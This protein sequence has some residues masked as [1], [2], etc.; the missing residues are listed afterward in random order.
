MTQKR[1]GNAS[2]YKA[3]IVVL[4]AGESP[5][6]HRCIIL[7]LE[8]AEEAVQIDLN[9]KHKPLKRDGTSKQGGKLWGGLNYILGQ[10]SRE[11]PHSPRSKNF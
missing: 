9:R 4:V 11:K 7:P 1:H 3:D 5:K 8:K 10:L 2:R 6:D